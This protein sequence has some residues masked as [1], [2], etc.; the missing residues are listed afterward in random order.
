MEELETRIAEAETHIAALEKQMHD[1]PS[2]YMLIQELDAEVQRLNAT[3][4]R[5]RERWAELADLS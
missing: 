5:D 4:E 2:D 1:N 3:L